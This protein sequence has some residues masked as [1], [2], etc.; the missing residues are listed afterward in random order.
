MTPEMLGVDWLDSPRANNPLPISE[1]QVGS[2]HWVRF[3]NGIKRDWQ[4]GQ[5]RKNGG[6]L[7]MALTYDMTHFGVDSFE[8]G[9]KIAHGDD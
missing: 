6:H 2:W 5:V 4:V 8:F 7:W 9:G 1:S 3:K